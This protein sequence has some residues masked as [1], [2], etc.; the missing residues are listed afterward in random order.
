MNDKNDRLEKAIEYLTKT[1]AEPKSVAE[2]FGLDND[3]LEVLKA[4]HMLVSITPDKLAPKA[5]KR[6]LRAIRMNI[7]PAPKARFNL[8]RAALSAICA[9]FLASTGIA[10]A[11]LSAEPESFLYPIRNV[12]EQA[13]IKL[14]PN[15]D[16]RAREALLQAEKHATLANRVVDK[17]R[18]QSK[19]AYKIA[20]KRLQIYKNLKK[21]GIDIKKI[22]TYEDRA[23]KEYLEAKKAIAPNEPTITFNGLPSLVPTDKKPKRPP[24]V[25]PKENMR[26]NPKKREGPPLR[27]NIPP[28]RN[29]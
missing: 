4:A 8:K 1:K 17:N 3:E 27:E 25:L 6:I 19:Q 28:E 12:I 21:S 2:I 29:Y 24:E 5:R 10:Y 9:I 13:A 22:A 15:M 20:K 11:S 7:I 26:E 16:S 14:T 23:N 18:E